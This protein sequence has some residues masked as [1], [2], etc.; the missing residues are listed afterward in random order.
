M[1]HIYLTYNARLKATLIA[2]AIEK[3]LIANPGKRAYLSSTSG[4]NWKKE[5]KRR[6]LIDGNI[7]CSLWKE[8]FESLYT[9]R[10]PHFQFGKKSVKYAENT[11]SWTV[12]LEPK[13]AQ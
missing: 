9:K 3:V 7:A 11:N 5:V 10:P 4:F 12:I 2:K 13:D 8:A 6:L 1:T